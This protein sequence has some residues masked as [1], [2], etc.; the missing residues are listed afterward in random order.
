MVVVHVPAML[1][2]IDQFL[3]KLSVIRK[4]LV[5]SLLTSVQYIK[6]DRT[7]QKSMNK[8]CKTGVRS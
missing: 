7:I 8:Q 1:I 4:T 6:L 2:I 5:R 3:R